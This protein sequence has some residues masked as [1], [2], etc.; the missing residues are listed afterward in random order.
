MDPSGLRPAPKGVAAGLRRLGA[1]W[2]DQVPVFAAALWWGSLTATG[3]VM[4]PTLFAHF[5]TPAQA[6]QA[7]AR[8]FTAQTWIA[9]GCGLLLLFASRQGHEAARMDW[10]RGA[11]IF[12]FAGLLLAL[13]AEFA[14]SPR[15]MTR[16]NLKLWHSVG[17]G[18]YVLQW[19]C[20]GVVLWKV[21]DLKGSS[22]RA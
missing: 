7:A 12:V 4:V 20:A 11:L 17:S 22:S 14:V 13:V 21:A 10:A 3:F 15:I 1:R 9:V 19:V 18:M 6:G 2:K 8:L 5:A 16:A